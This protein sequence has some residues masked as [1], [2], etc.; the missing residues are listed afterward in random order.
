MKRQYHC[1]LVFKRKELRIYI[2][3]D[4]SERLIGYRGG[5]LDFAPSLLGELLS[6]MAR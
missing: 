3:N 4:R 6:C 2:W 5:D 1:F